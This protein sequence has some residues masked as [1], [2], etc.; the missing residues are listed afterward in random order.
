MSVVRA[1]LKRKEIESTIVDGSL[2]RAIWHLSWPQIISNLGYSLASFLDI[3]IA[4]QISKNAQAAVGLSDQIVFFMIL[5]AIALQQGTVAVIARYWGARDYKTAYVAARNALILSLLFGMIAALS[6]YLLA[7]PAL[8]LLGA[9][10][11]VS[12]LSLTFLSLRLVSEIPGIVIWISNSIFRARGNPRVPLI[13]NSVS[14]VFI[15]L[16]DYVFCF[17][18]W[19]LGVV[20]IGL[21]WL[22]SRTVGVSIALAMLWKFDRPI[23]VDYAQD[24]R[25]NSLLEQARECIGWMKRMLKIGLPAC[26]GDLIWIVSNFILLGLLSGTAKPTAAQ[27]S[28]SIGL[29]F[30]EMLCILPI[31]AVGMAMGTIVGQNLGANKPER[32]EE[33][34]WK[35]CK[36][37]IGFSLL[38]SLTMSF[39]GHDL[40]GLMSLDPDVR[41]ISYHYLKTIAIVLPLI[42]AW[43]VLHGAM[44]GAGYTKIPMYARVVSSVVIRLPLAY[45]LTIYCGMQDYATWIAMAASSGLMGAFLIYLFA[46]G[47]WKVQKV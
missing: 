20:G 39:F 6:G 46:S 41:Q 24:S 14:V 7:K 21:S 4:G 35:A 30:E 47:A 40:A 5:L 18:P 27:A 33:A 38:I 42:G 28:W 34:G 32:A 2:W 26:T 29:Q 36:L 9:K 37:A 13:V 17:C 11:N 44:A 43:V 3:F 19:Q 16:G 31:S 12:E 1:Q 45:V 15:L 25:V 8:A 10:E 22:V 23:F